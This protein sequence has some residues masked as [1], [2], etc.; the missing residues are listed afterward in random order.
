LTLFETAKM[1]FAEA[2]RAVAP[3]ESVLEHLTVMLAVRGLAGRSI[4][5][6]AQGYPERQ[7]R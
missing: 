3:F 4:A 7:E 1:L 5:N 6:G 2:R